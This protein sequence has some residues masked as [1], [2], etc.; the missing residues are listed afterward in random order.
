METGKIE[1][2]KMLCL[3]QHFQT[4]C[5]VHCRGWLSNIQLILSYADNLW[6]LI[7]CSY[8]WAQVGFVCG[9]LPT[10]VSSLLAESLGRKHQT[11]QSKKRKW[12]CN[13]FGL[14]LCLQIAICT[15]VDATS[16]LIQLCSNKYFIIWRQRCT[17][18]D[19]MHD[20][21]FKHT[22]FTQQAAGIYTHTHTMPNYHTMSIVI[23]RHLNT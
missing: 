7:L 6:C 9:T 14:I 12:R 19:G 15:R 18:T 22:C 10:K 1:S 3:A 17:L 21:Q 2:V 16:W 8:I 23:E 5:Q 13:Q 4:W 20:H 11:V